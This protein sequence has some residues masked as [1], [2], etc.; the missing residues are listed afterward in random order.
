MRSKGE[1]HM[2]KKNKINLYD[3]T[4]FEQNLLEKKRK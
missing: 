2:K 1:I 3:M 4:F